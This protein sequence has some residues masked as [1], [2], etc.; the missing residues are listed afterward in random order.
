M[1][2]KCANTP[3]H[4]R[5]KRPGLML[6]QIV[7][8]LRQEMLLVVSLSKSPCRCVTVKLLLNLRCLYIVLQLSMN[9]L[10]AVEGVCIQINARQT[11][12]DLPKTN[13]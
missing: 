9:L 12:Q 4:V 5:Q 3:I 11:Q 8:L 13:A 1:V 6:Q 2:K 10:L 7:V